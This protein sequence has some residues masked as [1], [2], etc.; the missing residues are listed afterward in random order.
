MADATVASHRKYNIGPQMLGTPPGPEGP[1]AV[2]PPHLNGTSA[3]AKI[4][5]TTS[6]IIGS[7]AAQLYTSAESSC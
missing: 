7:G 5:H 4:I 1:S 3:L 6:L 2:P